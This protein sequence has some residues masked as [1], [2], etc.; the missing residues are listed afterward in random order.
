MLNQFCLNIT[1]LVN[2]QNQKV[3]ETT[4]LTLFNLKT[5]DLHAEW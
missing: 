4:L 5:N 1:V 2:F 3:N